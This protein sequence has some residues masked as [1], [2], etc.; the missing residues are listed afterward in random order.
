MLDAGRGDEAQA[1]ETLQADLSGDDITVA[2]NPFYLLELV[3]KVSHRV[4]CV[5]PSPMRPS[6]LVIPSGQDEP[7]ARLPPAYGYLLMR[8]A[9]SNS[10]LAAPRAFPGQSLGEGRGAASY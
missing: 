5:S 1:S 4:R 7:L 10:E 3:P 8:C 2:Y 9:A 6:P